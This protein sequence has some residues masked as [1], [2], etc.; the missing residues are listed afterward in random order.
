MQNGAGGLQWDDSRQL[1][2]ESSVGSQLAAPGHPVPSEEAA[3]GL[4]SIQ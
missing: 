4:N 1:W 2:A 3:S